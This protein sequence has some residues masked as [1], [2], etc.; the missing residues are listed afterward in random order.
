MTSFDN[1]SHEFILEALG[2]S[3]GRALIKQWLK[4]GYVET[5][6]FHETNSGTPQGGIVSPL[7]ANIALDGLDELLA[8][9]KKEKEYRYIQP[10]GRQRVHRKQLNRYGFIRYADDIRVTAE[11][12]EDIEAIV[13]IIKGWLKQRGLELNPEKTKITPIEEGV[14]FLGFHIRQFKGCCYTLPQ[15]EKVQAFLRRIRAWL[16][17]NPSAKPEAVIHTLN[18]LLRGWG[19]YYKHGVSKKMFHYVD[20][21]IW[22][23]LWQWAQRRHPHKAKRWIAQKYFMPLKGPR[24]TF[25]ARVETRH[26]SQKTITLFKL[27]DIPIER[28]IK[29]KGTASPDDPQLQA[30]W[31]SR[32][33]RYGKTYWLQSSKLRYVAQNQEWRCPICGQHL[34]N[35]EELHTHHKVS[36]ANGGSNK[37]ENLIHLHRVCHQHLHQMSNQQ[38]LQEA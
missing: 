36:V 20:H 23:A 6:I 10:N 17:A 35:G 19:N 2:H 12:K 28:H 27:M 33:T 25:N 24:W 34:F 32:Q 30:Y 8:T 26:G 14:D 13:P 15:K 31:A 9:Y 4:A 16:K 3:P 38:G 7:L 18:P 11:T 22:K 29:V 21:H 5:E 1:I 37:A